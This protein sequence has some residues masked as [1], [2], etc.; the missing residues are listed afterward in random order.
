MSDA[1][2]GRVE[3]QREAAVR[4]PRTIEGVVAVRPQRCSRDDGHADSVDL[5]AQAR[6]RCRV[7][8]I[9]RP[10]GHVRLRLRQDRPAVRSRHAVDMADPTGPKIIHAF[11]PR[12]AAGLKIVE[13]W[14][15]LGMRATQSHDT[16][17]DGV[18]V[19]DEHVARVVPMGA[20]GVDAFVL[21]VFA[22]A[23]F[24]F[25]NVYYGL[26][27][28]ATDMVIASLKKRTSIALTRSYAYHPDYQHLL[29]EMMI[30]PLK[31]FWRGGGPL[32]AVVLTK[33]GKKV[34]KAATLTF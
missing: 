13:N 2:A 22:W 24:G 6:R 25:A 19:A 23:L 34:S 15:V 21:S 28:H 7:I 26:A 32:P 14:D 8:G 17:L 30:V 33:L 12:D 18:F 27:Q 20:A 1:E 3:R 31:P 16:V 29:A 9:D 10:T 5:E 11:A 4:I